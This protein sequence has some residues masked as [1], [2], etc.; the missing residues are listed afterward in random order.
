MWCGGCYKVSRKEE[1]RIVHPQDEERFD[2]ISEEKY[3]RNL[4]A[5]NDD[6]LII[7]VQCELC[8]F[9][10]LKG[11]SPGKRCEEVLLLCTIRRANVDAFWSRDLE[12]VKNTLKESRKIVSVSNKFSLNTI[13]LI[14]GPFPLKDTQGMGVSLYILIRYLDKGRYQNTF[15][16]KSGKKDEVCIISCMVCFQKHIDYQCVDKGHQENL[17]DF[18]LHLLFI[19]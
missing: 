12:T 19:V 5:R 13:L 17:H 8:R 11:F 15:Q 14:I 7:P 6:H 3:S 18:L 9:K 1:Y 2:L 16:Y 10:N 4:V